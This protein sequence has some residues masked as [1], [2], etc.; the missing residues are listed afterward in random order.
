MGKERDRDLRA[1]SGGDNSYGQG[2][3]KRKMNNCATRSGLGVA[4]MDF[5]FQSSSSP[6]MIPRGKNAK[7][8]MDLLKKVCMAWS[9]GDNPAPRNK[10]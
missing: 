5:N 9:K 6:S 8:A 1:A 10:P 4:Q 7:V 2:E 3:W